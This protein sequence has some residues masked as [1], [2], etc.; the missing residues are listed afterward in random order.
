MSA[1]FVPDP[2]TLVWVAE[3][4]EQSDRIKDLPVNATPAEDQ[5]WWDRNVTPFPVEAGFFYVD[6]TEETVTWFRERARY[7]RNR[8]RA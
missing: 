1:E 5:E 7:Y 3:F 4:I 6:D 2:A 8:G